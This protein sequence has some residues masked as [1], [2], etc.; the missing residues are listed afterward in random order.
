ME[1]LSAIIEARTCLIPVTLSLITDEDLDAIPQRGPAALPRQVPRSPRL[2]Q[3]RGRC[4]EDAARGRA[5]PGARWLR[6]GPHRQP[7]SGHVRRLRPLGRV[8]PECSAPPPGVLGSGGGQSG[9]REREALRPC[10]LLPRG[11]PRAALAGK[12]RE[13]GLPGEFLGRHRKTIVK[14]V[15]HWTGVR[16][17]IVGSLID[18][19]IERGTA[20][21]LLAERRRT[22]RRLIDIIAYATTLSM[23]FLY[24]GSFIPGMAP[25]PAEPQPPAPE[26]PA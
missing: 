13:T 26:A 23:N 10:V 12:E 17:G 16:E 22:S 6:L 7:L 24:Q 8:P 2:R 11:P 19:L 20:L 21:G 1:A 15:S 3:R 18:H 5:S 25:P 14:R 9:G 4:R